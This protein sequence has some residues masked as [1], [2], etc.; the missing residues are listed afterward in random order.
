MK[1]EQRL[2]VGLLTVY[3][4]VLTWII[5]L[6]LQFSFADLDR[7]CRINLIPLAGSRFPDGRINWSE[8]WCNLLVFLPMGLYVALLQPK[9]PV[10]AALGAA[11][12]VSLSYEV[13]QF[14]LAIG[15]SDV[16]DLLSNTLGGGL[17]SLFPLLCRSLLGRRTQW[18]LNRIALVGTLAVLVFLILLLRAN[19]A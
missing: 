4:L 1:K 19:Q 9:R 10:L 15:I 5:L 3:L 13:L 6:K 17:G 8:I 14:I 18:L 2:T 16:T 7:V 11:F 12:G